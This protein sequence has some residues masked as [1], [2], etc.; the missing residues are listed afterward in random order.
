LLKEAQDNILTLLSES[1]GNILDNV[2]LIKT[3]E[4]SKKNS[5]IIK[6]KLEE[7]TAIE[8]TI[9]VSR[10]SYIPVAIRGT[11][12]YFVISDLALIDPMYQF[13]LS[14]FK[15]LFAIAIET[16]TISNDQDQ[17]IVNICDSITKLMFTD[18]CR[19]LFESHKKIYSFLMCTAIRREK[20]I[21]TFA[22]WNYFVR[23]TTKTAT[24]PNPDPSF[25]SLAGWDFLSYA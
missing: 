10:N 1:K 14:Y 11:V 7:T 16:S 2:E 15:K 13:S 9:N 17:R 5:T 6:K 12:L 24:A 21:I 18:I 23:G 3:L 25:L 20:N 22:E 8:E 4:E 19:G